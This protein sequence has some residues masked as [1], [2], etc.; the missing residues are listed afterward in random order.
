MGLF[1]I[2]N[3]LW[4]T[5]YSTKYMPMNFPIWFSHPSF[6]KV[7]RLARPPLFRELQHHRYK[8]IAI[9]HLDSRPSAPPRPR[10]R[11]CSTLGYFSLRPFVRALRPS[12]PPPMSHLGVADDRRILGP[13]MS[14]DLFSTLN[15]LIVTRSTAP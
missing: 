6:G 11:P 7:S 13:S 12:F 9:S 4:N 5:P 14:S 1:Y 10:P 2:W 8:S 15:E 3:R